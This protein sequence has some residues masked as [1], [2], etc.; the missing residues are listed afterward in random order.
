M[1]S[2]NWVSAFIVNSVLDPTRERVRQS[3][4]SALSRIAKHWFDASRVVD[5]AP[6][7]AVADNRNVLYVF[8]DAFSQLME[9]GH[10]LLFGGAARFRTEAFFWCWLQLFI[11]LR[12]ILVVGFA[13]PS[14]AVPP[15]SPENVALQRSALQNL[16][17][18]VGLCVQR[19]MRY[20][21][22]EPT[23][24]PVFVHLP[25]AAPD[26]NS[27]T[28]SAP[29]LPEPGSKQRDFTLSGMMQLMRGVSTALVHLHKM[30]ADPLKAPHLSPALGEHPA[31]LFERTQFLSSVFHRCLFE[32]RKVESPRDLALSLTAAPAPE[33]A[34]DVN[35]DPP[36]CKHPVSRDIAFQLLQYISN[37]SLTNLTTVR[38]PAPSFL[39]LCSECAYCALS[40]DCRRFL[41]SQRRTLSSMRSVGTGTGPKRWANLR[42]DLSVS[43]TKAQRAT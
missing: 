13:S 14:L 5:P 42:P 30:A 23:Y 35:R 3:A 9:S 11:N 20:E 10:A 37:L 18:L 39:C 32:V 28:Y 22:A 41:W 38:A 25:P 27:A 29:P 15:P 43:Q 31:L 8:F 33:A 36:L 4:A 7:P 17:K 21:L 12:L 40:F 1:Q 2:Q 24:N 19:V 34:A 26:H 6:A 16:L